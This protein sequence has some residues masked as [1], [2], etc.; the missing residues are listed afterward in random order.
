MKDS[1]EIIHKPLS[2]SVD[3]EHHFEPQIV[4]GS[5]R[6]P[7]YREPYAVEGFQL[8]DYWKAVRKRLWLVMGIAVLI[9]TLAA[10][11][12]ARKPNVYAATAR[13]QVDLEQ[14]NPELVTSDR[15]IPLANPDPSYFNTQLQLLDS[16]SLLRQVVKEHSLDTNKEFLTAVNE[17][18]MLRSMLRTLGLASD[19]KK[20]TTS[21][22]E[23][24]ATANSTLLSSEDIA[25]AVRLAPYVDV[26]R[27]NMGVEPVR[28]SRATV[29]D[30]RLIELSFR[31]TNPQLA[32]F[33]VNSI[34][35]T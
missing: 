29:K 2:E 8:L 31:H 23:F 14:P 33:V 1:R 21:T 19:A 20:D 6:Y 18:G 30:T 26:I 25:E 11:Y 12:M 22:E 32:A 7:A 24:A 17:V 3:L 27:R 9:T 15:A 34:G 28:E 35:E 13:I 16:E 5:G 4:P 10:I